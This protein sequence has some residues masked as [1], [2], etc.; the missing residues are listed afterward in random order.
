MLF[1]Q[2]IGG[3]ELYEPRCRQCFHLSK[4]SSR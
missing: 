1:V 4:R 2:L 3:S